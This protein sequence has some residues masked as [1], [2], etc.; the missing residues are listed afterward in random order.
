M[1][2]EKMDKLEQTLK[3][4][5]IKDISSL[6]KEV[7]LSS[8]ADKEKNGRL[9]R[10]VNAK[11]LLPMLDEKNLGECIHITG[12]IS[13][14]AD[15]LHRRVLRKSR[16]NYDNRFK[17]VCSL[18]VMQKYK[19]RDDLF[20]RNIGREIL[21]WIRQK[22]KGL[23]FQWID[24]LD[25]FDL[26][27]DYEVKLYNLP[28]REKI[29]Y[30]VFG[31]EYILLQAWHDVGV[32]VKEVWLLRSRQLFEILKER[33]KQI[34]DISELLHPRIFKELTLSLS[35]SSALHILSLLHENKKLKTEE[36][37][38][39]LNGQP[40]F[41]NSYANLEAAGFIATADNYTHITEQGEHYLS[42][43]S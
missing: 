11:Y 28:R 41:R 43:F 39:Q 23:R 42:L 13:A 33:A 5:G 4:L 25:V 27:G 31:D 14:L 36:L 20:Y 26:L 17:I 12:E 8:P 15:R 6:K 1:E 18:S 7:C 34:V 24:Y 10:R 22:W 40:S 19:E 35:N 30:S 21:S 29:H 2:S 9:Y 37:N 16:E 32:H 3:E 38:H